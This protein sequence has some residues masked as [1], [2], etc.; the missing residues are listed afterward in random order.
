[1]RVLPWQHEC[2]SM[3]SVSSL[4]W[5]TST[6]TAV[7]WCVSPMRVLRSPSKTG[8]ECIVL[9]QLTSSSYTGNK[10]I[11]RNSF[12]L[13]LLLMS[14]SS[15]FHRAL[16][17]PFSH[18]VLYG[19]AHPSETTVTKKRKSKKLSL[20]ARSKTRAASSSVTAQKK[21][22]RRR[23][24]DAESVTSSRRTVSATLSSSFIKQSHTTTSLARVECDSPA[25]LKLRRT[26][27]CKP[28]SAGQATSKNST[29]SKHTF[30]HTPPIGN[31]S[32]RPDTPSRLLLRFTS[33]NDKQPPILRSS[34][35]VRLS[36]C[37]PLS[38]SSHSLLQRAASAKGG[39]GGGGSGGGSRTRDKGLTIEDVA[40]G[41]SKKQFK[42]VIV[43]SGAGVSTASG[44][45][46]F[47]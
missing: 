31:S 17:S 15:S 4:L 3:Q 12:S 2:R 27:R 11:I 33:P 14:A 30:H 35:S 25:T 22:E 8:C 39:G 23:Q 20:S 18:R 36:N 16:S 42:N 44:I 24:K 43:M 29:S 13:P 19:T 10:W 38:T 6:T 28:T 5:Q 41:L 45:V 26:L 7:L 21:G 32:H 9:R 34:L 37:R 40:R 1:M 47:R 46:D